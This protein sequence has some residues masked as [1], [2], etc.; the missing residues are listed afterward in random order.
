MLSSF[1]Y[2]QV[3]QHLKAAAFRGGSGVIE[4]NPAYTSN[5]WGSKLCGSLWN[6]YSPGRGYSHRPKRSGSVGASGGVGRGIANRA[7]RSC[8]L[9][10]TREESCEACMVVEGLAADSSGAN[11]AWAVASRN[12]GK[13]TWVSVLPDPVCYLNSAGEIPARESFPKPGGKRDGIKCQLQ[14][15]A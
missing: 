13:H 11:S 7:G 14:G 2:R 6:Q 9:A 12:G 10:R 3:I 1:A 5:H 15:T 8:H 4:V